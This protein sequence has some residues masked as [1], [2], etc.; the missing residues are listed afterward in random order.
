MH[1]N[2]FSYLLNNRL[3]FYLRATICLL[4]DLLI[5]YF[6]SY[7]IYLFNFLEQECSFFY[8]VTFLYY[9]FAFVYLWLFV[10]YD[11]F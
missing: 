9:Y 1:L 8:A 6:F 7:R 4:N 3:R 10:F 11:V 5:F 2:I